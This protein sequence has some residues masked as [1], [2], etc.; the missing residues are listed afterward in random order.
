MKKMRLLNLLPIVM[1][2]V[3]DLLYVNFGSG[4]PLV[5]L[6]VLGVTSICV[7]KNMKGFFFSQGILVVSCVIGMILACCYE[8]YF[9]GHDDWVPIIGTVLIQ[10]YVIALVLLTLIGALAMVIK[11]KKGITE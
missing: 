11:K 7:E 10:I 6:L 9:R 5:L 8:Y 1:F 4:T 3:M 2:V